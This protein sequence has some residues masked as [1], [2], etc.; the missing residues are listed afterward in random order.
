MNTDECKELAGW[1]GLVHPEILDE[2]QEIKKNDPYFLNVTPSKQYFD[3]KDEIDKLVEDSKFE[4]TARNFNPKYKCMIG[5][6][7]KD[8][9]AFTYD[10]TCIE[11]GHLPHLTYWD[12][13]FK[14]NNEYKERAGSNPDC[15]YEASNGKKIIKAVKKILDQIAEYEGSLMPRWVKSE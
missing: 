7:Y 12:D 6:Y 13:F 14:R 5:Y 11:G 9:L 2:F 15:H 8:R 1:I 4:F 3:T 10:C